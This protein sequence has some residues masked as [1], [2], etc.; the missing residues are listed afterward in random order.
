MRAWQEQRSL[1]RDQLGQSI[2]KTFSE[3]SNEKPNKMEEEA[4]QRAIELSMLDV[5]LVQ[6]QTHRFQY[7]Q[8]QKPPHKVL[9]IA[10]NSCPAEIKMAYRRLARLHVSRNPR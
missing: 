9:G 10:E 1:Q 6:S 8:Q 7:E 4:I 2:S 5:A 3:L